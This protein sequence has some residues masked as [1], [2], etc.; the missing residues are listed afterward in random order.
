MG[1]RLTQRAGS[2]VA[3]AALALVLFY[4][5]DFAVWKIRTERG[6]GIASVDVTVV[7]AGLMKGQKEDYFPE[8]TV[9][10][11]CSNSVSPMPAGGS[12]LQPCWWLRR[13]T[14]QVNRV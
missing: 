6:S 8:G 10:V 12:F 7:T 1:Q 2:I 3:W 4:L 11:P 14:E 13:H 5:C 9:A